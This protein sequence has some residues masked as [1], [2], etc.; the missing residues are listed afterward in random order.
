VPF[1][2]A[3]SEWYTTPFEMDPYFAFPPASAPPAYVEFRIGDDADELG[4]ID[5][6]YA[7][8]GASNTA[9]GAVIY[10]HV[11]DLTATFDKLLA[12]GAVVYE[13]VTKRGDSEF[14]T[15]SVITTPHRVRLVVDANARTAI[16]TWNIVPLTSPSLALHLQ[17]PLMTRPDVA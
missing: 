8:A 3:A 13:A 14:T 16:A 7:P 9:G 10:W 6:R 15:A 12:M 5:R 17:S 4:F 11:D 1:L 2:A